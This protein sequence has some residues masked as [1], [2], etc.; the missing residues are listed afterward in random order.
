M[1]V[2]CPNTIDMLMASSQKAY[3]SDQNQLVYSMQGILL[4]IIR[5]NSI[6]CFDSMRD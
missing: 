3:W 5:F 6:N 2:H 4:S 1:L